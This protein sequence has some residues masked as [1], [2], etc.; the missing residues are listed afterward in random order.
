MT[1]GRHG[2]GAPWA[3]A[4]VWLAAV[5]PSSARAAEPPYVALVEQYRSGDADAAVAALV[6]WNR[7][8]LAREA[9]PGRLPADPGIRVAAL[10]LHTEVAIRSTATTPLALVDRQP[11]RPIL[12]L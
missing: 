5:A 7:V 12:K 10:A 11:N 8:R 4:A 2:S 1:P 3:I 6:G 9:R